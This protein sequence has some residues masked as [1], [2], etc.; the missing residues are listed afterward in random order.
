MSSSQQ[1]RTTTEPPPEVLTEDIMADLY[2]GAA[3]DFA[4]Y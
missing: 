1:T 2:R 3:A 4:L